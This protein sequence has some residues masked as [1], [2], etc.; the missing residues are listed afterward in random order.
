MPDSSDGPRIRLAVGETGFQLSQ[1][2]NLTCCNLALRFLP[3]PFPHLSNEEVGLE[4]LQGPFQLAHSVI[5]LSL[6]SDK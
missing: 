1:S 4:D 3:S 6:C 5:L 2:V